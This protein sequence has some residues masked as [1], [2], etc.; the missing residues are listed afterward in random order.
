VLIA[1]GTGGPSSTTL[2]T[3]ELYRTGA[4]DLPNLT[5]I[6]ITGTTSLAKGVAQHLVATG[7][8]AD[9]STQQLNTVIWSS[10]D[11]TV[12]SITNDISNPGACYGVIVGTATITATIGSVSGSVPVNV[13]P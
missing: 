8:F 13:T 3:A 4:K 5:S 6:T 7:H 11:N 12:A 10:S 1:G 2:A 9:G